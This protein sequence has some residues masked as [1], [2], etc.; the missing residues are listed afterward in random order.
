MLEDIIPIPLLY[1]HSHDANNPLQNICKDPD[2]PVNSPKSTTESSIKLNYIEKYLNIQSKLLENTD[3]DEIDV[4]SSISNHFRRKRKPPVPKKPLH[5]TADYFP[6]HNSSQIAATS[7]INRTLNQDSNIHHQNNYPKRK[8]DDLTLDSTTDIEEID[9]LELVDVDS[10]EKYRKRMG[11]IDQ[12]VAN[13]IDYSKIP[14]APPN[15]LLIPPA[16]PNPLL[17]P[18]PPPN[19]LLLPKS[20]YLRKQSLSIPVPGLAEHFPIHP[21]R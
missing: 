2:C 12:E 1:I 21:Y 15:P 4:Y 11:I 10:V 17:I 20:Y 6:V 18:P 3:F 5:L 9:D 8:Q 13:V 16:P 7:S 14:A 19:P